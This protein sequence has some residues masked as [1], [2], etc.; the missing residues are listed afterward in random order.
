MIAI[1]KI[2][3]PLLI[4]ETTA[5]LTPSKVPAILVVWEVSTIV[6]LAR[7]SVPIHRTR[8]VSPRAIVPHT[9]TILRVQRLLNRGWR[10]YVV[11]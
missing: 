1:P 10:G 4:A 2:A 6:L 3:L 8:L 9:T 11:R 5:T 7:G